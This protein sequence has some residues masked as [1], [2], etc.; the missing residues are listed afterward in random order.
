MKLVVRDTPTGSVIAAADGNPD[1]VVAELE[2]TS[3]AETS[4]VSDVRT[5]KRDL[6]PGDLAYLSSHDE[7]A[8]VNQSTLSATRKYPTVISFT[9]S[10]TLDRLVVEKDDPRVQG[11]LLFRKLVYGVVMPYRF[12]RFTTSSISN[13]VAP[14]RTVCMI[15]RRMRVG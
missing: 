9:E 8:L 15:W 6:K 11:G 12:A 5:P 7:Q 10:D 13:W 14:F 3:V 4:A 1:D 2:V